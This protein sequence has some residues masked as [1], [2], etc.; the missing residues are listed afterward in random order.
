MNKPLW[1][2]TSERVN[3][4]QMEAFRRS[5]AAEAPEVTDTIALHAWSLRNPDALWRRVWD[6]GI[7]GEP[8]EVV[9]SPPCAA[10]VD[11]RSVRFFPE[12][13]FNLAE[14]LLTERAGAGTDAIVARREGAP[15]R[16]LTWTDLRDEV[17]AVRA[18]LEAD[19]VGPGDRV[20][21][22]MPNVVETVVAMLAASALG[23]VFTS[24]S[25]DF[26]VA[27]VLDR[28]G[29]TEPVVLIAADGYRYGGRRL[30]V[31][32]RLAEVA[33]GLASL[34]RIVVV[35][36]FDDAPDLGAIPNAVHWTDYLA[37]HRGRDL[38][39]TRLPGDHPAYVLYSSGTTGQPKCIVHR[40]LGV[41]LMHL[42]E[43][44]LHLDIGPG[45]R[46]F[47]FT[48]CGWM[49]WNWLVSALAVGATIVLYDGNPL[50]PDPSVLWDLA[51]DERV[52]L[53]GVSAKYLDAAR[54]AGLQ[55]AR[56][57]DLSALRTLCSTGSPLATEGY[58]YVYGSV[59]ADV[60]LASISGGTDLCGC[61]VGGD[62]T[63][64]VHAGEIQGPMLG[65]AVEVLDE[66]GRPLSEG[67]GE[68]TCAMA[69][70]S[71]PLGFWGDDGT[72]F[73][74][75]YFDRFDGRWTHGDFAEFT[76]TGG[77][78][79]HGRSDATLNAGGVRIGT[80]ELYSRV[81][82]HAEIAEAVAVGQA[83]DGDSRMV[84][85]VRMAEGHQLTDELVAALRADLRINL[86]PRHVPARIVRVADIPRTRSGKVSELAVADVVN[87][88][89]VRNV[90]ALA[91]ADSLE[92]FRNR[93]ELAD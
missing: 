17:A 89:T 71:V 42:K 25:S 23:A 80:A 79:I 56:T 10:G 78:V 32:D 13:S 19:G 30:D 36:M 24:T 88:R 75:A 28:F 83:F 15:P 74:A 9:S 5:V 31:T 90:G 51:A 86:S 11:L 38:T 76:P 12:S 73:S 2:P 22:W 1:T 60:H 20:A 6:L 61:F 67:T 49:M 40:A 45:D 54:K 77:V 4:S 57:H 55:P 47:Y 34:R 62:P 85:F 27:G 43:Q 53:M 69:F 82:L 26:G 91:N 48:T 50:A 44:R 37:P 39:F 72:S 14:N 59:H 92:Q 41:L 33:A 7:V 35:P 68:L 58:R 63:R 65:M 66:A 21:A 29:Q 93:P 70:P 64:P 52:T 46:V 16:R 8:G 87:G 81:E 3:A 84:L 18:A